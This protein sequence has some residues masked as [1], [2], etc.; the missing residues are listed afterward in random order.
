MGKRSIDSKKH[1]KEVET[2]IELDKEKQ[3]QVKEN[4]EKILDLD[5]INA[6]LKT[7]GYIPWLC[8]N[9]KE[10]ENQTKNSIPISHQLGNLSTISDSGHS[11]RGGSIPNYSWFMTMYSISQ[12]LIINMYLNRI[13]Y[14]L[15]KNK[16]LTIKSLYKYFSDSKLMSPNQLKIVK[17][18]L[19]RYFEEDHISSLH[20]L[21]PQ[22]ESFLLDISK[23]LGINTVALDTKVDLATRTMVLSETLLDS[24]DFKNTFGTNFCKQIKFILFEPLGYKIR[25]KIAHGEISFTECNF[26]NTTLVIYLYLTLLGR[27]SIKK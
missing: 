8:P 26:Q 14:M 25:H 6:I 15:I 9:I 13:F 10:I 21:V 27:I 16:K 1:F 18:G 19:E 23:K 2:S 3:K 7:I 5:N 22:F 24:D 11:L 4:I 20:I 17:I 12:S